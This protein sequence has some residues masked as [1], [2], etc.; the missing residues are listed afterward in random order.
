MRFI[1]AARPTLSM[2]DES[3]TLLLL[4]LI[5]CAFCVDF[6]VIYYFTCRR[7]LDC[8]SRDRARGIDTGED[9]SR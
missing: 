5:W 2:Y 1:I 9:R 6:G 8:G 4:G 7:G 3:L